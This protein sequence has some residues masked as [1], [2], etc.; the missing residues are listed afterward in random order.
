MKINFIILV[1]INLVIISCKSD[2]GSLLPD[3]EVL[4]FNEKDSLSIPEYVDHVED[5]EGRFY[6]QRTIG[7]YIFELQFKPVDY[8]II[9]EH[10]TDPITRE[11]YNNAKS[12]FDG[13][14]YFTLKIGTKDKSFSPL[15]YL[16][17]NSANCSQVIEYM[18]FKLEKDICLL[19]GNETIPCGLFHFER[20]YELSPYNTFLLGFSN[21]NISKKEDVVFVYNDSLF[22]SGPVN[23]RIKRET[24]N[25]IPNLKIN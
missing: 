14:M 20:A 13:M 1:F 3:T 4:A 18:S 22:G 21:E 12:D 17:S 11:E 23:F 5:S 7:D 24:I 6:Q 25:S 16:C 2:S 15:R 9:K 8:V 10:G 19:S